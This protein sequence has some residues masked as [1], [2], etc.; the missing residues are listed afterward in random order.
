MP[1]K[2]LVPAFVTS[3]LKSAFQIGFLI[4]IPFL[5]IDMI[6]ASVLMSLGMMMLSPVLDG[7]AVQADAVRAGRRLEPAARLAGRELRDLTPLRRRDAPHGRPTGLHLR[8]ARPLHAAH[9]VGAGAARR[10]SRSACVVSVFQ[11]ATQIHEQT[12]SFVPKILAAVAVLGDRR[13]VDA[14]DAGRVPAA[15]AAVHPDRSSAEA[16]RRSRPC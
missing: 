12:L 16:A 3:E 6:V 4:F 13:A 8:P 9:G 14:D 11:A 1:F 15:H 7:A 5:I 2:V 10:C